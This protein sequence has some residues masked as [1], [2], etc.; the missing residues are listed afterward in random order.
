MCFAKP[1]CWHPRQWGARSQTCFVYSKLR[2]TK[3]IQ[4]RSSRGVGKLN[5]KS[6]NVGVQ[7]PGFCQKLMCFAKP[8]CWHPRQWGARSQTCFLY[9]KLR[10]TKSIQTR[11]SRGVGKLNRKSLNVG[12][13]NPGFCQKLMCFVKPFCWHPRQ[14]GARSQT[15]FLYSKLRATKSIQTRSSRGV[16]KL[17]RKSLNV[18]V[19]NPGFCQKLMCFVK[20]FCWHPRQWGAR[21]QTCFLYSKLRATK[22]I[23]TRSS[24][25]VGKLNRKSL[26]VGVQNPGFCQKLMCFAKPF[27]WHPRQWGARSQTCFLYSKLR[28]T[29]SIQTR[30]SRGVGKLNRKSL[31]V[32]VQNPGFC[33][34]LMCFAKT[35]CWHPRQWGARSQTCFLYSKLRATESIQTR[36]SRGVGKLNRKSLN[37]GVQNPGFCQKLMCFA[38]PFCWHPRQWGARSQTCFLYSKLRATKSIQTRSSRGVGKLNRKSLNVGVQN[39]G[40]CQKL[41]C[42]VKPFCWHPR[43]WGARSQTC[44]LYSKLRATKSIQTRSSRGVGKLNRKSLN[45]GVQNP[46]FCQKLMCFAKPF[47]WH[48]RQ[49]GARSQTCFLYSKLRATKSIQ[50]RS[51]RGVGKLNRKSLNVGV[52]NPG[53]CQKLMCFAKPFCWHPRQWGARSQTCFVYSKLRATKSIQTRSSRGVGKLNRKSLN[54]GV[55]NPGFCQKLMCFAKPFC[56]HPRQWGARSQT[57]FLYSKLRAT[58]SIQTRSSRGVGKLN[59]KSLNVG[60]QNPGFCQKLMCFAKPFCWHPRQWGARSQTCFLYSKLRATKSIQTRSSRGVGKLNRKSLNVGVQNPGFCQ[61]L[62]CFAKPFCWHP[63][64]WGARSQTCFLYSKL[65]ATKSIQTRSSRGVGKLNRK[66]LNVGVQNPGFC[67]KLMCFVKP[68]CWHPRQWGARSQTCFLYSKLRA[69][70]S[71][72]TRS[73]RGVGKLNRKS[74][75]V[76]VQNPGF[77][78]K[79]MCFAKPFCWHPRQ[80]GARSQNGIMQSKLWATKSIQTRSSRGV[81]KLNRKSL[82]VGVQNPGFCQK[83]MCFA[84]PFCWHPRQWGARSQTCFLYSKLRATKSIQTRSSRG[85][86][87]LNRKSLNVGVQNPGFCQKLMCFAKPFCWHPRQWG[88]RSQTCFLYSK[89]RATKSIQTRSSRGVGK[90][91]RKSLNVGVQNPGFCQK[92]MCF[93]KPF[94][95]H[96]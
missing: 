82:N 77:C 28:A 79:L 49:W 44:F 37:V 14:W 91:N 36:S 80:W 22:S 67:Q 9:S 34:K 3:S 6:L 85:V 55:Q 5:R 74:L 95:W 66:S 25:G 38:K 39:P 7:N 33:Q 57:C 71:I 16:G 89:L 8:F 12:V 32:G 56:W 92:L 87:K 45:V 68:F 54:V 96:P 69:T 72:Q 70:K 4:T 75:N 42:F 62:M 27:C 83:L 50:T 78:Q 21:S 15:C 40:F 47:C 19:Q 13:Q 35:F 81:G 43:Q 20:P 93:V 11:S 41:M 59:R 84:K 52:Q 86:G 26:N 73:S 46:G 31:N 94:C 2:A 65:R 51:S 23:Q 58:K 29:K 64:Q 60:V 90:L 53:F 63:R 48:P 88:A 24:R 17:N 1:F 30:S 18:G 10:A 76:G 61:K